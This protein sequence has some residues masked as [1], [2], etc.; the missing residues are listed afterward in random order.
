MGMNG[1]RREPVTMTLPRAL[2]ARLDREAVQRGM[3]AGRPV[4]RSSVATELLEQALS[5]P[6]RVT[7]GALVTRP[8]GGNAA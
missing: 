5:F 8:G 6:G 1:E 4:S 2:R 3:Q 7:G